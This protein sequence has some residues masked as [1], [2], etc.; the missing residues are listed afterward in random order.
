LL[1]GETVTYRGTH[2]NAQN[3]RLWDVPE[4]APAIGV[5]VSG[6]DSCRLAGRHA[7]MMIAVQPDSA[8]GD[9]FDAAGGAGKPRVGQVAVSFDADADVACARARE[10]FRWFT[11]GWPVMAELP[12][13]KSFAAAAAQIGEDDVAMQ[14]PCGNDV[15]LH[16]DAV[17][18]FAAAGFT[19]VALV[20]IGGD[21]QSAFLDW[22]E[23]Q[24]L[25]QLRAV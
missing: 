22:A 12:N 8:L 6:S 17:K 15:A 1:A 10:Q 14:V 24:L 13:P 23:K 25:P 16:V 3:A 9:A 7:D 2:L 18:R 4:I 20:Q 21:T 11:G 5:A 19:H